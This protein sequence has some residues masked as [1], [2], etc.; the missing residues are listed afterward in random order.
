MSTDLVDTISTGLDD[1]RDGFQVANNWTL[2]VCRYICNEFF[3]GLEL[4]GDRLVCI[5]VYV[6]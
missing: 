2:Q 5:L 4:R 1:V 6:C 3:L